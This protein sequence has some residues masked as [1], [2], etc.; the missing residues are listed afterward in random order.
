MATIYEVSKLA[1]VSLATVSRVINHSSAVKQK[2]RE[3]VEKAMLDL[4]YKPN[5]V[6][7]SLASSR[8][9]CVGVLVSE[10][11]GFFFTNMMAAIEI[12]CRKY[13]KHII[14]TASDQ[15]HEKDG[16]QF[17]ISR[18]CDALIIQVEAL[19]DEYL[20]ELCS[21]DLPI[22]IVNR[23]IEE[24]ADNCI[25][26][27]NEQGQYLAT[28]YLIDKGHR[29]IVYVSG[30]ANKNDAMMRLKGYKQALSDNDIKI[31]QDRIFEGDY[32]QEGG[33]KAFE[34]F[35]HS[36]IP[37]TAILCANDEMATAVMASAREKGLNLPDDL[38][39]LG[40]DDVVFSRYTYPKL[41]TIEHPIRKMGEMAARSVLKRV[42]KK[43][44]GEL[45]NH[46]SPSIIER[47]SV[48]SILG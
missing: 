48:K 28:Q 45:I 41:T 26:V 37:Y 39:I 15:T 38:S 17:L 32:L 2:T 20:I 36:D 30:P 6:A 31:E 16:I 44:V 14:A 8:S 7:K 24:I 23:Y 3:K 35:Y 5:S 34:Y 21:G 4:N 13:D 42:Y 1:G 12:E 46:F 19:S 9:D 40:F 22:V 25:D 11:Q 47:D 27:D 29:E 33:A 10:L 43:N 18:N